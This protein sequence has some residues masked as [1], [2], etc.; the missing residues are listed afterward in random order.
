VRHEGPVFVVGVPRSG[1]STVKQVLEASPELCGTPGESHFVWLAFHHPRR[2]GWRSAAVG[3]GE[4][5]FAERRFVDAFFY[6]RCGARRFVDK[7]PA[8]SLRIPHIAELFPD[9][10]FVVVRRDP[11]DVVN[12]LIN[13]WRHPGGRF[14]S[15]YVPEDLRIPDHPHRRQWRFALIPGWRDCI[16]RP[17]H[18]VAFAQWDGISRAIEDS[19]PYVPPSRWIDLHVED[20]GARPA[21]T[22]AAL[23]AQVGLAADEGM[24]RRLEQLLEH[25][26]GA[27]S[28]P[29][30]SKWRRDNHSEIAELLPRIAAAAPA[31]GYRVDE[32]TGESEIDRPAGAA[33]TG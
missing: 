2:S 6:S 25:P 9:A 4:V 29:G 5:R 13:G 11:C 7:A 10:V 31:R 21:E 16:G 28:P 14:R 18:E 30:R 27:M 15:Y 24:A 26:A 32:E 33:A 19:R 12:S 17:I 20:L 22:L 3:P 8:N 23:C 1:T